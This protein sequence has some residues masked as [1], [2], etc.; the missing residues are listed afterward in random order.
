[1]PEVILKN[2]YETLSAIWKRYHWFVFSYLFFTRTLAR[3][4]ILC[5]GFLFVI[6]F[7]NQPFFLNM[8]VYLLMFYIFYLVVMGLKILLYHLKVMSYYKKAENIGKEFVFRY[9]E[10]GLHYDAGGEKRTIKWGE[11]SSFF[12][13]GTEI[14]LLDARRKPREII[15]SKI[16]DN[17]HFDDIFKI[18]S[19]K[20]KRAK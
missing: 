12:E 2:N 3:V 1:M 4:F 5:V 13:Y 11:F 6:G 20:V 14:Y 8:A 15:S 19:R 16:L 17:Q 9:D 18:I 7:M 10:D